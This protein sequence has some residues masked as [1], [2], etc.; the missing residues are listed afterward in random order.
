MDEESVGS[1]R[2]YRK[3]IMGVIWEPTKEK[4]PLIYEGDPNKAFY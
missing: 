4:F 2:R 3:A 1:E